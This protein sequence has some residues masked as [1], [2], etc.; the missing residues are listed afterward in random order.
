MVACPELPW[1]RKGVEICGGGSVPQRASMRP[2]RKQRQEDPWS[3]QAS[4]P[5]LGHSSPFSGSAL[6]LQGVS[7]C[8]PSACPLQDVEQGS[9]LNREVDSLGSI[10]SIP[11]TSVSTGSRSSSVNSM[12]EVMDESSS[13]LVMMQ[14]DEGTVN[15]SSSVVHKKVS[16]AGHPRARLGCSRQSLLAG[17]VAFG[18]WVSKWQP[19]HGIER[20][21]RGL[22]VMNWLGTPSPVAGTIKQNGQGIPAGQGGTV[23]RIPAPGRLR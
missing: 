20:A 9:N 13:E 15:S 14:E 2:V 16:M 5:R 21:S 11:S 17:Q 4:Q 7:L 8:D 3:S 6:D 18:S 19:E 12:Q 10:H 22:P 1:G 23:S